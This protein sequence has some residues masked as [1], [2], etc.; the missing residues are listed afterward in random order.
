MSDFEE[1]IYALVKSN[2]INMF[3]RKEYATIDGNIYKLTSYANIGEIKKQIKGDLLKRLIAELSVKQQQHFASKPNRTL[4]AKFMS[5]EGFVE[6]EQTQNEEDTKLITREGLK[7]FINGKKI[8]W[9][10]S[11][12]ELNQES[13]VP[14]TFMKNMIANIIKYP[15]SRKYFETLVGKELVAQAMDSRKIG[16]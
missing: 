10:G 2:Y 5:E 9:D 14:S 6:K 16:E 7:I 13:A 11:A 4:S 8:N 12:L 15:N 1:I 3:T